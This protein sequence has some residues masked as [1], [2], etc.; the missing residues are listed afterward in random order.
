MRRCWWVVIGLLLCANAHARMLLITSQET[1]LYREFQ[2]GLNLVLSKGQPNVVDVRQAWEI[3]AVSDLTA[4]SAIVVAGVEAAK[5]LSEHGVVSRPVLYT[6]LPFS[7]YEWLE[8]NR[9]LA[10]QHKVLFIDQPPQRY[11]QLA[12]AAMPEMRTIGYLYGDISGVY[13][14]EIKRAA[15]DAGIGFVGVDVSSDVKFS[16]LLKDG[17][18]SSDAVL[19]LPDPYLF[20]RRVVQEVL[21]ASFRYKRPLVVYSESFL[22]AGAMVALFS[23]PEQI[24]RQTGELLGCVGLPC[25]NVIPQRSYPKYFS[26]IVNEF[27]A[28]Q[29]GVEIKS[30]GE[31][32]KYLESVEDSLSH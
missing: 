9:M 32:L 16:N 4:Y 5:A 26:V 14:D 2:H 25:Y 8:E 7:S 20:N 10:N 15:D 24:G 3:A 12:Q 31:L 18:A 11:V 23:T 22:K 17:F 30:A 28:R 1:A 29:L 6:M 13:A 19:L 21:L 27:V